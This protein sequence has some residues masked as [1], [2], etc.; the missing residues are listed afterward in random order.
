MR[1]Y[2]ISTVPHNKSAAIFLSGQFELMLER[3]SCYVNAGKI[4]VD[5]I[6]AKARFLQLLRFK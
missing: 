4:G 5:A 3:L 2:E 6:E 1:G